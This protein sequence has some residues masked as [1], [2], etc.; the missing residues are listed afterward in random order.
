ML[1]P[2]LALREECAGVPDVVA[3]RRVRGGVGLPQDLVARIATPTRTGRGALEQV[4]N[5]AV[6]DTATQELEVLHAG[7]EEPLREGPIR[8]AECVC[9]LGQVRDLAGAVLAV[10]AGLIGN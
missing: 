2:V 7:R 6:G 8:N 1:G 3:F 4:G 5:E 9:E 10:A